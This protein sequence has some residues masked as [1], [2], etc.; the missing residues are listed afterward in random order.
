MPHIHAGL[1]SPTFSSQ[2]PC[3]V[4]VTQQVPCRYLVSFTL[5]SPNILFHFF[6]VSHHGML[7]PLF[8]S[9][10]SVGGLTLTFALSKLPNIH[11]NIYEAASEFAEI[12]TGI[13][14]WWR[15]RQVLTSLGL[16]E[17]I[18]HLLSFPPGQDKGKPGRYAAG[19]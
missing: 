12:G 15:S 18:T 14:I 13:S 7:I 17:H 1:P 10:G 6:Q 3:H 16:E 4:W 5:H 11:V 2:H 9:G 19:V 8:F